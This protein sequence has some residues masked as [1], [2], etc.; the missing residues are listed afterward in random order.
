MPA[1]LEY[2]RFSDDGFV[3]NLQAKAGKVRGDVLA[4]EVIRTFSLVTEDVTHDYRGLVQVRPAAM[5]KVMAVLF[6][7]LKYDASLPKTDGVVLMGPRKDTLTEEN[8]NDNTKNDTK[9]ER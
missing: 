3:W 5:P 1:E 9:E 6:P 8:P 7:G 4:A 2:V